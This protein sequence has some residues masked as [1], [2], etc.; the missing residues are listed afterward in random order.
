MSDQERKALY[1]IMRAASYLPR[2]SEVRN[3]IEDAVSVA[4]REA[5]S[6]PPA[7]PLVCPQCRSRQRSWVHNACASPGPQHPWHHDALRPPQ[8]EGNADE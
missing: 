6:E 2:G 8:G 1:D 7:E 4:L 5:D 3:V